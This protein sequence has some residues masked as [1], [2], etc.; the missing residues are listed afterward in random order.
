MVLAVLY[1]ANVGTSKT[2]L[3]PP[4]HAGYFTVPEI[5]RP[6]KDHASTNSSLYYAFYESQ[7]LLMAPHGRVRSCSD[8]PIVL[9]L[10][11]D[12]CAYDHALV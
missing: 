1:F 2:L 5:V 4:T 8:T 3:A 6:G 7:K 12:L 11:V 9:W 10:Q